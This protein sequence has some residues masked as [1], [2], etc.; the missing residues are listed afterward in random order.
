VP[1]APA[2][3]AVTGPPPRSAW[4]A[5]PVKVFDNL[6]FIGQSEHRRGP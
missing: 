1:P 5:E 4:H 2:P 3:A 6:Y